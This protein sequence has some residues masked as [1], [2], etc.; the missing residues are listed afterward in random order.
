MPKDW[1]I[2]AWAL[3]E[4]QRVIG[5][6]Q[7]SSSQ[8]SPGHLFS[9]AAGTPPRHRR[10]LAGAVPP[11]TADARAFVVRFYPDQNGPPQLYGGTQLYEVT[12]TPARRMSVHIRYG[13]DGERC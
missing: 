1:S 7:A 10:S 13:C 5:A 2:S 6:A 8:S 4:T 11:P 3:S 9:G 12:F